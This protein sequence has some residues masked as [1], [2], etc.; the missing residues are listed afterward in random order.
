MYKRN[1]AQGE[2]LTFKFEFVRALETVW[3]PGNQYAATDYVRPTYANGYEYE[4]SVTGQS[5]SV[6]PDWPTAVVSPADTVEDGSIVWTMRPFG[7]NAVDLP[8]SHSVS[9]ETGITVASDSLSGTRVLV[10]LSGGTVGQ[11]YDV[12]AE[13]TTASG[14][15]Y[16][17]VLR[18][19]IIE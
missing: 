14:E 1:K 17:E 10:Q 9:A 15:I 8:A 12:T 7:S 3:K 16:T 11:W 2:T 19:T 4:A 5:G 18:V 6:E 13:V